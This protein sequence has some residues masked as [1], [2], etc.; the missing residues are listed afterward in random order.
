MKWKQLYSKSGTFICPYCLE[1]LPLKQASIDHLVPRSR[2]GHS[3]SQNMVLSC[4]YCNNEKGSLTPQEYARWK[5][6][7]D[8]E[9][10]ER[11]EFLRTGRFKQKE[12]R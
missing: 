4:K 3:D 11:L 9:E 10:W 5:G 2:G 8:I 12:Q 6:T 1:E 7:L